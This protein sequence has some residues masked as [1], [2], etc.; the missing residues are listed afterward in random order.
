MTLHA[1]GAT[2]VRFKKKK[3]LLRLPGAILLFA[4]ALS[5]YLRPGL[6][7]HWSAGW[8]EAFGMFR[9]LFF[10]LALLVAIWQLV[11][12]QSAL[13]VDTQGIIDHT[14]YVGVGRVFWADITGLRIERVR[15]VPFLV[16]D[17]V[18]AAK[19]RERGKYLVQRLLR[20]ANT[21]LVGSPVKACLRKIS[22]GHEHRPDGRF[23][24]ARPS[25]SPCPQIM[26]A[27][28]P[29]VPEVYLKPLD[30]RWRMDNPEKSALYPPP[31]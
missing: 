18:D 5:L 28:S 21:R 4:G 9:I 11:T 7:A 14:T 8:V 31:K 27:L 13:V 10:G 24:R 30:D 17:V 22:L 3:A 2:E 16:V 26:A 23:D 15:N 20:A 6:M 1:P 12:E 25:G 29:P 19:F